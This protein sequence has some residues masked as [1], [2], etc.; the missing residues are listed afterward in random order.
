MPLHDERPACAQ[1][2]T[3]FSLTQQHVLACSEHGFVALAF[4]QVHVKLDKLEVEDLP[5][6]LPT[7]MQEQLQRL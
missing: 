1:Q 5:A 3:H 6:D 2:C 4:V 7:V